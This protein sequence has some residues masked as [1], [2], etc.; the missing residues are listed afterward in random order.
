[1][2]SFREWLAEQDEK[3]P[4]D[5]QDKVKDANS[6]SDSEKEPEKDDKKSK[7]P[8]NFEKNS[9][10]SDDSDEEQD[11]DKDDQDDEDDSEEPPKPIEHPEKP[12]KGK[13]RDPDAV[14]AKNS[15]EIKQKIK[16]LGEDESSGTDSADVATVDNKINLVSRSLHKKL[17]AKD[18]NSIVDVDDNPKDIYN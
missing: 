15:K 3:Q 4:D 11:N 13:L 8:F 7:K 10:K 6:D 14:I 17:K 12:K 5:D 16:E 1:M 2:L 9:K 18:F